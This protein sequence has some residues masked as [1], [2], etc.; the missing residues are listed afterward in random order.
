MKQLKLEFEPKVG[1]IIYVPSSLYLS[2]GRDDFIGGRAVISKVSKWNSGDIYI[3][4]EARP[5]TEYRWESL[6]EEQ[7]KLKKQYKNTIAHPD[8]DYNTEFNDD[9][10]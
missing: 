8:P 5:G 6:N 4:V 1:D 7:E 2:H 9:W 10:Y 3:S